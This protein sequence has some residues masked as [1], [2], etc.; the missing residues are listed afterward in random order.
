MCIVAF[1]FMPRSASVVPHIE[2]SQSYSGRTTLSGTIVK[3]RTAVEK[4]LSDTEVQVTLHRIETNTP[5]YNKDGAVFMNL[6]QHLPVQK[7]KNYYHE[8][9]VRTPWESDRGARR[10]IEGK[11]DELYFT[12]DHYDSFTRV[13]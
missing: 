13:R 6:E 3:A 12:D 7:E 4:I 10:I 2:P 8:W 5:R 1:S 9:T 11:W